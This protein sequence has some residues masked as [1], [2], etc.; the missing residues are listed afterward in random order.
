MNKASLKELIQDGN[1]GLIELGMSRV[2]VEEILGS[3]D[4]WGGNECNYRQANI[5][6]YGDVEFYFQ[7][8]TLWMIFI[9]DCDI[10]S[11]GKKVDLDTWV[12]SR[13]L[14][15]FQAEEYLSKA[16]IPYRKE[17]FSYTDNGIH[18]ITSAGTTLAFSG[19]SAV[20]VTLHSIHRQLETS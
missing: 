19:E 11:G 4:C 15:C 13:Y 12:I 18:L 20:E 5:W 3:P 16:T 10:P 1:F 2:G 6:K 9:D 8:E 7:D 14:I 17:E